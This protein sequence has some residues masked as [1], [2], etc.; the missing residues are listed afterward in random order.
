MKV[1]G[2]ARG[3]ERGSESSEGS[4]DEDQET[5][6]P[7]RNAGGPP[8]LLFFNLKKVPFL[9]TCR[10]PFSDHTHLMS[11]LPMCYAKEATRPCSRGRRRACQRGTRTR[12]LSVGSVGWSTHGGP[13]ALARSEDRVGGG[14][15]IVHSW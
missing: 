6:R 2:R 13:L 4:K 9:R 8:P 7:K 12:A 1:G 15:P 3:R 10:R 11:E 5:E 14:A